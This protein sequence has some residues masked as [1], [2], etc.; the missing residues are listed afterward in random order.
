MHVETSN[1]LE[2]NIT[3]RDL[4]ESVEQIRDTIGGKIEERWGEYV[5]TVN[6]SNA[7]GEIRFITFDWGVNLLQLEM[8]FHKECIISVDASKFNPIQFI[9]CLKGYCRHSFDYQKRINTIEQ[10]QSVIITSRYGGYNYA[11]FPKDEKL[12]LNV[13]KVV[14]EKYLKKRLN[15]VFQLKNQLF[16]VFTDKKQE[17]AYAH[18]GAL[19][20][21]LLNKIETLQKIKK[22]GITRILLIEGIVYQILSMHIQEY[23]YL[24]IEKNSPKVLLEGELKLIND[25]AERIA[26]SVSHEYSL[27]NLSKETGLSKAKL[28]E[29]FKVLFGRTV[30]EYIRHVRLETAIDLI[31]KNDMNMSEVMYAIGFS[32]RSYFSKIF[33]EKYGIAP[34]DFKNRLKLPVKEIIDAS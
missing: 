11:Y 14:R 18:F 22:K 16:Q 19:N 30:T 3:G 29:G 6:N 34:N 12:V 10:H 21:K 25:L 26:N 24:M 17:K 28:Q 1:I 31:S 9:Y 23:E 15:N 20:F 27:E 33:K 8:V 2:C 32:S 4:K 7:T 5:L 13:I